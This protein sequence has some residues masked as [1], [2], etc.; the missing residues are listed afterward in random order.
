MSKKQFNLAE[1]MSYHDKL[2]KIREAMK[3]MEDL[4]QKNMNENEIENEIEKDHDTYPDG[5]IPI[6]TEMAMKDFQDIAENIVVNRED[7][8]TSI[9]KFNLDQARVF[10]KITSTIESDDKILRLFVSGFGG[11]GKSFL[12]EN[13]VKWNKCVRNKDTAVTA[14]TGIAAFNIKGLTIHRLLQLPV[15][16]GETPPYKALSAPAI[17]EI[18]KTLQ[19]VDVIIIDE[20]SMVSNIIFLYIHLRLCEIFN[21]N[22]SADPFFGKINIILFGGLLQLPPVKEDFPF[23]QVSKEK[24]VNNVG[25][26]DSCDLWGLFEYDELT[27]NMRQKNDKEYSELLSRL[28]LGFLTNEDIKLLNSRKIEFSSNDREVIVQEMC[29]Y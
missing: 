13:V 14:H 6:E 28:R 4:V 8:E 25:G 10:K 22:N 5:C 26:M 11:T 16:Q 21:T 18:R 12:I 29:S 1:A 7:L 20:I 19:N 3:A 15:K 17:K 2:H 23:I 27:I 9:E 24:L